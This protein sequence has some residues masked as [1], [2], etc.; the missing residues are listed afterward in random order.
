M[1]GARVLHL[2]ARTMTVQ[3]WCGSRLQEAFAFDVDKEGIESYSRYIA[4]RPDERTLLLVDRVEEEF[5]VELLPHAVGRARAQ[6]HGRRAEQLFRATPYRATVT[7]GRERAGRRDDR[8]LVSALSHPEVVTPWLQPLLEAGAPV[9]AVS[10]VAHVFAE[11]PRALGWNE[12]ELL[13][14]TRDEEALRQ[15]W[16]QGGRLRLSRLSSLPGGAPQA[17]LDEIVRTRR[18]LQ[19]NA[20]LEEGVELSVFLLADERLIAALERLPLPEGIRLRL[21]AV[22]QVARAIGLHAGGVLGASGLAGG[23][24]QRAPRDRYAGALDRAGWRAHVLVSLVEWSGLAV[25]L[26]LCIGATASALATLEAQRITLALE[27]QLARDQAQVGEPSKVTLPDGLNPQ[28]LASSVEGA[29]RMAR[30][31]MR[32]DTALARL[33]AALD[34]QPALSLQRL[35]WVASTDPGFG[36]LAA[37]GEEYSAA[38]SSG[39]AAYVAERVYQ[40]L[41]VEGRVE[42]PALRASSDQTA[43]LLTRLKGMP[44][45]VDATLLVSPVDPVGPVKASVGR[46][47]AIP[48]ELP[49]IL[50]VVV[51]E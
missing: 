30:L 32:P 45:V 34:A 14:V 43:Q 33:G 12:S 3:C 37:E 27:A 9:Q 35:R 51:Q 24:F 17:T 18:Y 49:F 44:Q 23:L 42:S 40:S 5:A 48:A 26:L 41:A 15:S 39:A 16:F 38:P 21:G 47:D 7:L 6:L 25:A 20:F 11:L 8:V 31:A 1:S 22:D 13:L 19:S 50:R 36:D 4:A 28:Q 29:E 46:E 10:S 2:T